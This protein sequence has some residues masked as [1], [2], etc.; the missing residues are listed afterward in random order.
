MV[1]TKVRR[2]VGSNAMTSSRSTCRLLVATAL[3]ATALNS[4][5]AQPAAITVGSAVAVAGQKVTGFL[6][7]PAGVDAGMDLPVV[8]VQG[9]RPGPVVALVA[10]LHGTEYASIIALEKLIDRIDP[11]QL[12]G[13]AIILPLVNIASFEQKVPHINPVDRKN[14]NRFFPG[15]PDGTQTERALWLITREIV[16]KSDVL[17]DYHGGD[18]D[19]DLRPYTYW[20]PVGRD[21]QDQIS[22]HMSLAFGLDHI[23]IE[24]DNPTD[25]RASKYLDTTAALRGK[26]ALVVEAGRAGTVDPGDV[27]ALVDG[28]LNVL[29][30]LKALPGPAPEIESPVW[31]EHVAT[32]TS[33]QSGVFYPLVR[34]GTFAESGMRIGYVTDLFGK[35]IYEARAPEA[36]VVLY[37]CS[38]PSMKIGDTIASI[39]VRAKTA[40]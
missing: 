22:R 3:C 10:G 38:V 29:R 23:V 2:T 11:A 21:P 28:T 14:M 8:I 17:I 6:K 7:V 13:T 20:A 24:R 34:R 16:D 1:R 25:L 39:G 12:S 27:A 5:L 4:P 32:V 30:Y 9:S 40:P 26:P 36:G 37:V 15:K 19:E 35:T 31:I 18:L 33:Q